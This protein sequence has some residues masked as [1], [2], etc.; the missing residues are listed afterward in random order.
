MTDQLFIK[1]QPPLNDVSTTRMHSSRMRTGR[2][3]TIC[4]S[5]LPKESKKKESKI[6]FKKK[7]S[8]IKNQK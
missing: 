3:L 5:L 8:K 4:L 7:K 1:I 2:S 6:F